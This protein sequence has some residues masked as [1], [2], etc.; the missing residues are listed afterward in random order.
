MFKRMKHLFDPVLVDNSKYGFLSTI[1][2]HFLSVSVFYTEILIEDA[3]F[4]SPKMGKAF[5]SAIKA[6]NG[7]AICRANTVAPGIEP[8]TSRFAVKRSTK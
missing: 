5:Y 6:I 8:T 2:M 7:L 4:M 1:K 3:I